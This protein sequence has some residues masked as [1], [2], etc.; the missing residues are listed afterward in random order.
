MSAPRD[1][2]LQAADWY[3]DHGFRAFSVWGTDDDGHCRC[4]RNGTDP[5][6]KPGKHPIPPDGFKAATA[7]PDRVRTMLSAESEPN[8]GVLPP[9]G[10][11]GWDLDGEDASRI[12]ELEDLYGTLPPTMGHQ[13][14][15]GRHV[16]YRWPASVLRPPGKVLGVVTRWQDTGYLVGAGSRIGTDVYRL[17]RDSA[18]DPLP[19]IDLPPAW[20]QAALDYRQPKVSALEV[21]TGKRH[22][23]LVSTARHLRGRGVTGEALYA[24][25]SAINERYPGGPKPEAELRDI[26]AYMDRTITPDADLRE[27]AEG[28][29]DMPWPQPASER[30]ANREDDAWIIDGVLRPGR[31]LILAAAEG[32]GKSYARLEVA[33]RCATG[34]GALFGHYPIPE[35]VRVLTVDVENGAEEEARREDEV[36]EA[37]ELARADLGDYWTVSLGGLSLTDPRDQRYLREA[38]SRVHPAVLILDTGSSMVGDEWGTELKDAVRFLRELAGESGCAI[39]VCV[40]LVKPSRQQRKTKDAPVHGQ[41]LADVMGQWTRSADSVALMSSAGPDR[42]LWTMRKRVSHSSLVLEPAGGIFRVVT[43]V[44]GDDESASTRDRVLRCIATG[45]ATAADIA[46]YLRVS[47]RTVWRHIGALRKAGSVSPEGDLSLTDVSGGVS[48]DVSAQM[49]GDTEDVSVGVSGIWQGDPGGLTDMSVPHR[50]RTDI[51]SA[52][53]LVSG[54]GHDLGA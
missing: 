18:G 54:G 24:A 33:I 46:T 43:A 23:D 31:L 4:G 34:S 35:R 30:Q 38:V 13:T 51:V 32:V 26:V 5:Q 8:I 44:I 39:V 29:E 17:L 36:L 22:P 20:V 7:D 45:H 2:I 6:H 19:I 48:A 28:V 52:T 16:V 47:E 50:G 42:M 41:E 11:F 40:H 3:V 15:H 53:R 1:T 27:D 12:A 10:C 25:L 37:L 21:P 14:P 9:D 49:N